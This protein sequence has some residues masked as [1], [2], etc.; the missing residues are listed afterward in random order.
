MVRT[1]YDLTEGREFT[2]DTEG[3]LVD[4]CDR[5]ARKAGD[6]VQPAAL[7]ED[8]ATCELCEEGNDDE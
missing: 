8:G 3:C 5:C 2:S 4:L 1:Y 7:A 6:K